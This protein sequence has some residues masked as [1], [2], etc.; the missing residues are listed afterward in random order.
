MAIDI[1][2]SLLDILGV[3]LGIYLLYL[4]NEYIKREKNKSFLTFLGV[5]KIGIFLWVFYNLWH[6]GRVLLGFKQYLGEA[7]EYPEY[8][9]IILAYFAFVIAA[10]QTKFVSK[11]FAFE[12]PIVQK[13]APVKK[14]KKGGRKK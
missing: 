6:V 9:L 12:Q 5:A 7:A 10:Y 11:Q 14:N 13:S 3:I 8:L 4:L 1:L 2:Y